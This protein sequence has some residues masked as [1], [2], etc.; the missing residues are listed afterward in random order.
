VIDVSLK[1]RLNSTI[2]L[3]ETF[4]SDLEKILIKMIGQLRISHGSSM[5]QSQEVVFQ[6]HRGALI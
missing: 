5:A 4:L 3:C 2:Q 6:I 1:A